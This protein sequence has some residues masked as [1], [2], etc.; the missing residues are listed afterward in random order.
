MPARR[1]GRLEAVPTEIGPDRE[2]LAIDSLRLHEPPAFIQV[3]ERREKRPQGDP[4][5]K[6]QTAPTTL[7]VLYLHPVRRRIA[8]QDFQN[9]RWHVMGMHIDSHA[10]LLLLLALSYRGLLYQK[11]PGVASL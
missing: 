1:H 8:F 10:F 4:I 7:S 9:T 3:Q 6:V 5:A 2:Q 11:T